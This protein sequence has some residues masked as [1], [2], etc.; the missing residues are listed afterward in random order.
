MR[1]FVTGAGG[2]VGPRLIP[3]LESEGHVV[4]ATD[5]EVDV[6]DP[7]AVGAA[8]VAARPDAIIH[9]AAQ[10]SVAASMRDPSVAYRVNFIG[11]RSVIDA[12]ERHA[13]DARLLLVGSGD[14]YTPSAPGARPFRE[15]DPMYPGSPYARSKAAAEQLG[16]LAA[17]RGLAVV[18]IRAF[19]HTGAGQDTQFV[20]PDFG[21]Q[22]AE[23]AAGIRAPKMR[24]G[25]LESVR[26]F[27][28]VD[29]V[30][31]AYV[32]LLEP[33]APIAIYNVSSG[34]GVP[35]RSILETLCELAGVA[36][37]LETDPERHRPT[38]AMVGDSARLRDATGWSPRIPLRESL[39]EVLADS[40]RQIDEERGVA[41]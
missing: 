13:P 15:Q 14:Q 41:G 2:F 21:R 32:R 36:P 7:D 25:N 38:N 16:T 11:A 37:T 33:S 31:D 4:I 1:V 10:S 30:V 19:N 18:R 5:R 35:V 17:R 29:D 34:R 3:R 23:I 39:A 12:L 22:V 8:V 24:V 40:Q 9:L 6:T 26:D 20:A 27:L 28:H